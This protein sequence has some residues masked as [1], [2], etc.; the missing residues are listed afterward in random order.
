MRLIY[1]LEGVI[2]TECK[3]IDYDFDCFMILY[4]KKVYQVYFSHDLWI[5]HYLFMR[6]GQRAMIE[7]YELSEN[8][9]EESK[10]RLLFHRPLICRNY[11]QKK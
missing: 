11:Y 4:Q 7:G 6:I 9:I 2:L 3:H 5:K 10:I 1:I 8:I